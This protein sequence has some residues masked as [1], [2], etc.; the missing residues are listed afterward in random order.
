M[1]T[2]RYSTED[3]LNSIKTL[4]ES[5]FGVRDDA[6]TN[7]NNR[8]ILLFNDKKLICMTGC[9]IS[10]LY[11]GY[12]IDWTCIDK[13]EE[14]KG[15]ITRILTEAIKPYL[16]KDIYCSC[17]HLHNKDK[18]NLYYSMNK[19]GFKCVIPQQ[20]Q[21]N[22][23]YCNCKNKCKFYSGKNCHCCEDTYVRYANTQSI[24]IKDMKMRTAYMKIHT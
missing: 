4:I 24:A 8:Y 7:L 5:R 20:I 11:K 16:N 21:Y 17:L 3:D 15:Y 13:N 6:Y 2:I 23:L 22:S 10:A 19:L 12:E 9:N 18:I 14:G 1:I